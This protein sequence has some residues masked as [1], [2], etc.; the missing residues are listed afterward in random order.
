MRGYEQQAT[1]FGHVPAIY[2]G[3]GDSAEPNTAGRNSQTTSAVSQASPM[4]RYSNIG[5]VQQAYVERTVRSREEAMRNLNA[6]LRAERGAAGKQSERPLRTTT[7]EL[8]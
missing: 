4:R 6:R 3:N 8:I 5:Q 2:G 7:F 1:S